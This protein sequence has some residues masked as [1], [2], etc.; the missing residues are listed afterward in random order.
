MHGVG[1]HHYYQ[2]EWQEHAVLS[3]EYL[4]D[5]FPARSPTAI[6]YRARPSGVDSFSAM[7]AFAGCFSASTAT[8]R[9]PSRPRAT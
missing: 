6:S 1:I 8:S 2:P 7:R 9:W 4:F 5:L 3:R